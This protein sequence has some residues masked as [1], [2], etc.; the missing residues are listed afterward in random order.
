MA[1]S[2]LGVFTAFMPRRLAYCTPWAYY[3]PLCAVEMTYDRA[4]RTASYTPQ[5]FPFPLLAAAALLGA[6]AL[7]MALRAVGRQE[8]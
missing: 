1:C 4:A 6:L 3:V 8:V 2:L 7:G 5:A